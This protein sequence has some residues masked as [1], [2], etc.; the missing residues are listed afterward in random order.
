MV[1]MRKPK[2][3]NKYNLKFSDIKNLQIVDR[4]R[5]CEP[6]FWRNDIIGAWCISREIG[7][8]KDIESPTKK[9][10]GKIMKVLMPKVKGKAD[11]KLVNQILDSLL[12]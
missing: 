5:I 12:S 4:S 10:K 1:K 6:L 2:V 8:K 9:E 7:S 3:E 11:G